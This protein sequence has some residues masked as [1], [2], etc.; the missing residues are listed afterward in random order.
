MSRRSSRTSQA[1]LP[2]SDSGYC[3][4]LGWWGMGPAFQIESVSVTVHTSQWWAPRG[5]R[6]GAL[7]GRPRPDVGQTAVEGGSLG[8]GPMQ[9]AVGIP[10]PPPIHRTTEKN[11]AGEWGDGTS[12]HSQREGRGNDRKV[13]S[14][15]TS[16][17]VGRALNP[18]TCFLKALIFL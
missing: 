7:W 13:W 8:E 15:A 11:R 9:E 5:T 17:Q 2:T 10:A 6:K 12:A 1:R 18:A 16:R 3:C 4:G 14:P